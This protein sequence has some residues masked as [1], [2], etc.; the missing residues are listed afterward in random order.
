[1]CKKSL[2]PIIYIDKAV[3]IGWSKDFATI[4]VSDTNSA[5]EVITRYSDLRGSSLLGIDLRTA[6]SFVMVLFLKFIETTTLKLIIRAVEPVPPTIISRMAQ[7]VKESSIEKCNPM[8]LLLSESIINQKILE[9][10]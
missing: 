9:L 4:R 10:K 8:K 2:Y 6:S 1:M 7:V 5:R 3:P